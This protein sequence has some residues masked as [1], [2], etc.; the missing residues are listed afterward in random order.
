MDTSLEV[1]RRFTTGHLTVGGEEEDRKK[2][3]GRT[4][5]R[6]SWEA[7]TRKKIWQEIGIFGVWERIDGS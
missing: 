4:K 5:L 7:K 2:K 3:H 6:I 1:K